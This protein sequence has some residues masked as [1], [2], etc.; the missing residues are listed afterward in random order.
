MGIEDDFLSFYVGATLAWQNRFHEIHDP[1]VQLEAATE[2]IPR[3]K[4]FRPFIRTSLSAFLVSPI[5]LLPLKFAYRVWM[6]WHFMLL[7]LSCIWAVRRFGWDALFFVCLNYSAGSGI[8]NGQDSTWMLIIAIAGFTLAEKG[9][10]FWSGSVLGLGLVKF[11]L[12]LLFLPAMLLCRRS[13][14]ALGY[15]AT[16][17]LIA[18][19]CLVL[20]GPAGIAAYIRLLLRDDIRMLSPG[21]QTMLNVHAITSNVGLDSPWISVLLA[22]IISGVVFLGLRNAPLW[23]WF[24]IASGGSLLVA[25]HVYPYDGTMFILPLWLILSQ[26]KL[27]VTR[28]LAAVFSSPL[29]FFAFLGGVPWTALPACLLLL[30]VI[31]LVFEREPAD[32]EPAARPEASAEP[33]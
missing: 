15:L 18:A 25:P 24:T 28:P 23:K 14:M 4:E 31:F 29:P 3:L 6:G 26:S 10:D 12:G 22:L 32:S 7:V 33:A 2:Q 5:S 1:G 27:R 21:R 20:G 8:V 30:I 9:R 19:G 16:A 11:H 17:F 13:K